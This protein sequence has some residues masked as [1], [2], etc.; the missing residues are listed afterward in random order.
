MPTISLIRHGVSVCDM[1]SRL[2]SKQYSKWVKKYD[3]SGVLP[4]DTLL[5]GTQ[6]AMSLSQVVL[7][8]NLKR[9]IDSAFYLKK[10][11]EFQTHSLFHEVGIPTASNIFFLYMKPNSWNIFLRILWLLGYSK[12]VESYRLAKKRAKLAADYLIGFSHKYNHVALVGHGFFNRMIAKQL[13]KEG[14]QSV[15]SYAD[16]N[17]G[18]TTYIK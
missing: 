5:E 17:W 8:S 11:Y 4:F 18:C 13:K 2:T 1:S 16:G 3:E 9:S 10:D 12:D 15:D 14:W 6:E 7:T